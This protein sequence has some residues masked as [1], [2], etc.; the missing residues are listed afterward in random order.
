[1]VDQDHFWDEDISKLIEIKSEKKTSSAKKA[2]NPIDEQKYSDVGQNML[3][4]F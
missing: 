2:Y 3:L 1:M 4:F